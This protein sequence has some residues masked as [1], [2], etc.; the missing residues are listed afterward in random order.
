M[1]ALI[2]R[3]QDD[4]S[5]FV[6]FLVPTC[7]YETAH[8]KYLLLFSNPAFHFAFQEIPGAADFLVFIIQH[9]FK[10]AS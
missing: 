1:T 6:V 4:T 2:L 8:K 7:I 10:C 9:D 3:G 5:D